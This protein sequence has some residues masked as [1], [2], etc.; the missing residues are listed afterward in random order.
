MSSHQMDEFLADIYGTRETIGA[1]DGDDQEKLAE[2]R[3]IADM[4]EAEG[5]DVD[6]IS[7]D[8]AVKIAYEIW[9]DD[10]AIVKEATGPE[11][12]DDEDD[13]E[14]MEVK[15]AQADQLGRI[16][17]HSFVQEQAFIDKE[18]G[19]L[20]KTK[21]LISGIGKRVKKAPKERG[22]TA[23]RSM[24]KEEFEEEA[25]KELSRRAS[26]KSQAQYDKPTGRGTGTSGAEQM[27]ETE[28]RVREALYKAKKKGEDV[29]AQAKYRGKQVGEHVSKHRGKYIAGGGGVAALTAYKA[30]KKKAASAYYD[31]DDHVDE[32]VDGW[33][34]KNATEE[35]MALLIAR[36]RLQDLGFD[37]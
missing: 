36:A 19:V 33:L 17:A 3:F 20:S 31:L 23:G 2:A 27:G 4:C 32:I 14:S 35:D 26:A 12:E 7:D 9:G 11:D 8:D 25:K 30:G 29:A 34:E 21:E 24:T 16:M 37:V 28:G 10:S 18:G 6:D 15:A 22:T 13:D 1:V 5:V